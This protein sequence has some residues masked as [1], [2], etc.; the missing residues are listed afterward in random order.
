M[1]D[2]SQSPEQQQPGDG[3]LDTE[4]LLTEDLLRRRRE[5]MAKYTGAKDLAIGDPV[6]PTG[7][8]RAIAASARLTS[9]FRKTHR[10]GAMD[11]A[12]QDV[13]DVLTAA[14]VKQWVLMGL[15]GL[16]GYLPEPRATQDVHVLIAYSERRRAVKAVS[17]KWPDLT[18]RQFSEVVRFSDPADCDAQ[19]RPKPVVDL[20]MPWARFQ[21]MILEQFVATDP[22]TGHRIPRLEAAL[23]SK[24]AAMISVHRSREKKEYDAGDFRR[25]VR[26]NHDRIRR[27]DLRRLA[28][29]VWEGGAEEIERFLDIALSDEPFPV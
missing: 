22:E 26:A 8:A 28:N 11:I 27:D 7:H 6:G 24:Y 23:V 1:E 25:I 14:G 2:K 18:V 13:I 15:H 29:E 10:R 3:A 5:A 16:V 21:E 17:E 20:M 19:G 12:P 4:E 9:Q